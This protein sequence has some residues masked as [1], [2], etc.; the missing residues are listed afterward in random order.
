[1]LSSALSVYVNFRRLGGFKFDSEEKILRSFVRFTSEHGETHIKSATAIDWATR[2]PSSTQREAR[3]RI[4]AAFAR[5]CRATDTAHEVPPRGVFG[6]G[7]HRR[8]VAYV[9]TPAQIRQILHAARQLEPKAS[10]RPHTYTTLLGLLAA[11][12][13]RIGE[14]LRLYI[15]DITSEGLVIRQTKF[16]KN[17]LVPLHPTTVSA[18]QGY[19]ALRTRIGG[20]DPHV[21]VGMNGHPLN[22]AMVALV[23][24]QILTSLGLRGSRFGRDP[25]LHDLRHTWVARALESCPSEKG[26]I[27]RHARAVMTYLGHVSV[28]NSYW[29]IHNTPALMSRI[30]DA[31]AAQ[32][33][34]VQ[35]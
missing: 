9:F 20:T 23:F 30:A 12:G 7:R 15:D 16:R 35:S 2:G 34:E 32:E 4:V 22:R 28:A 25:R 10:L 17:R 26:L 14:A 3:L 31:F 21:F 27:D 33:Q 11:T 19:L 8:P 24:H 6:S 5:F 29:Y 13:L 1:M 18:L